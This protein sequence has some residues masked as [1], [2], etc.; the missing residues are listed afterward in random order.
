MAQKLVFVADLHLAPEHPDRT[1]RFIAFLSALDG[2]E[3]VYVLGDLFD[4]WVGARQA[5]RPEWR[6]ILE[7][8][9]EAV[10][11]GPPVRVIGGNRDYLLDEA[12]LQPFGLECL[13]MTHR[14]E[15][16]GLTIDLVHGH[17]QFPDPWRS[18]LFLRCIQ[19]GVLR[20]AAHAVPL[21][22]AFGVAGALRKWRKLI[23][24]KKRV[25]YAKRYDPRAFVPLFEAGA[26]VIVCGHNHWARDYSPDLG[27]E[28]K[29]LFA[30][31]TWA[32]GPSYLEYA[33]G[34][35]LLVDPRL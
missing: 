19:S 21:W 9:G 25:E 2:V 27:L 32:P 3:A 26:D 1:E 20:G 34:E 18:R 14:L 17:M 28:G 15:R 24:G 4:F 8:L 35:F 31:G 13:G 16:D 7:R 29:R 5:R 30:V 11:D 12:S 22:V 6:A 10:R 23:V 33:D